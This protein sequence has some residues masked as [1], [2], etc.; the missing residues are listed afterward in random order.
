MTGSQNANSLDQLPISIL[1]VRNRYKV[2]IIP[3]G[4]ESVDANLQD[5]N[6]IF[7]NQIHLN[8]HAY[9]KRPEFEAL[10]L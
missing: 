6:N 2:Q 3:S 8:D 7:E 1:T 4:I 10:L 9:Y 5:E